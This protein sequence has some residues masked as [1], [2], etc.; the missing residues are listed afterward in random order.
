MEKIGYLFLLHSHSENI[1]LSPYSSE[2]DFYTRC[3]PRY[4]QLLT[5][6]KAFLESTAAEAGKTMVFIR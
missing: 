2:E 4:L 3:Y 5:K 1:H 6:A